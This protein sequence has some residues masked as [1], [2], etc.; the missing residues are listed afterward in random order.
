MFV[1][2][3]NS[4]FQKSTPIFT[5]EILS[6]F[7]NYSKQYVYRM[8]SLAIVN[9]SLVYFDRGIYYIPQ[10]TLFGDSTIDSDQ[11]AKKKYIESDGC[12]FGVYSGL[13]VLNYFGVTEQVPNVIEIVT[14]N[15]ATRKRTIKIANRSFRLRKAR[16]DINKSNHASYAILQFFM[17]IS[18]DDD[19]SA[20]IIK[21]IRSF[22]EMNG[23]TLKDLIT[24]AAHFPGKALKRMMGSKLFYDAI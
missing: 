21:R 2:T 1:E 13:S 4:H 15:E 18:D 12:V 6:L 16:C 17:E 24:M 19:L 5:E 3:L 11:I 14:N 23:T 20:P 10:K 9:G 7:P 8:I 22:M